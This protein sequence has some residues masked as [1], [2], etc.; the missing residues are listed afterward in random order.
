ML[1]LR[2]GMTVAAVALLGGLLLGQDK[3]PDDSATAARASLPTHFKRLG[4]S[5]EQE[6]NARKIHGE[7]QA[8]IRALRKQ[9]ADL[10]KE[11]RQKL[12]KVLTAE[13]RTRLRDLRAGEPTTPTE[14]KPP[15]KNKTGGKNP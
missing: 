11:E 3:K 12:D 15:A 2:V 9:I 10:Q 13:Q 7:Y 4:L 6:Q 8:K 14:T 5:P 1:R